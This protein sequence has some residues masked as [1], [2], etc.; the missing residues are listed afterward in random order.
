MLDTFHAMFSTFNTQVFTEVFMQKKSTFLA[1]YDDI[2][3]DVTNY[4]IGLSASI[5]SIDIGSHLLPCDNYP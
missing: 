4:C 3:M 5:G 1:T 2:C